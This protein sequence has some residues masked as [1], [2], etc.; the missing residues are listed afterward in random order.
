MYLL[1]KQEENSNRLLSQ[2]IDSFR[3]TMRLYKELTNDILQ[4]DTDG[5]NHL[6]KPIHEDSYPKIIKVLREMKRSEEKNVALVKQ[7]LC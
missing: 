3:E 6:S 7:I 4:Q 5:W 2:L 1:E